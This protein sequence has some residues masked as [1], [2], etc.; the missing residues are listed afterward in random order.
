MYSVRQEV[1]SVEN[2]MKLLM[3]NKQDHNDE[4]FQR[5]L[6]EYMLRLYQLQNMMDIIMRLNKNH[7]PKGKG[8]YYHDNA[9]DYGDED[10]DSQVG[11]LIFLVL[12][13]ALPEK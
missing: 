6:S 11:C 8:A 3:I 10:V 7:D 1:D 12:K 4:D 13:Q 9:N 2:K 5:L